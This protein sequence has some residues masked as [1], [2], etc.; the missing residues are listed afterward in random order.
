MKPVVQVVLDHVS[1]SFPIL[2]VAH[3]SL[4]KAILATATG[5]AIMRES[6]S[7]P[8]V[9]AL[10]DIS[11]SFASGDRIGLIGWNGAGKSTLLRVI[12]GIYEPSAGRVHTQGNIM[13]L[14]DLGVGFNGD[15]TGRE[16]IRLRGMYLGYRP[17]VFETLAP[18]IEEFT[19]L[20]GY[21]DLP[22]RTYSSGMQMRLAFGI[23]TALQP[24]ILLM[25]EWILAGDAAFV[26]RAHARIAGFVEKTH[27]LVLASHAEG[28]VRQWC[29]KAIFLKSGRVEMLGPV[30]DVLAEY[31]R[32][33]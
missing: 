21:L 16:N 12:A 24:D 28:I 29:N 3:R 6:H 31:K 30:D 7:A 32:R 9:Q 25:D 26:D 8:V 15:L 13:P 23:A 27:I 5:G 17:S 2:H 20:G 4:K 1:L 19:E 18:E 14:L 10:T 11:C 22:V 33:S